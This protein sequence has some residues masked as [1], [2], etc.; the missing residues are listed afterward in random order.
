MKT[1]TLISTIILLLCITIVQAQTITLTFSG[2]NN[3]QPVPLEK[4][5]VENLNKSCDTTLFYPNSTLVLHVLGMDD[6]TGAPDR[7][8]VFQNIPNPVT[9]SAAIKI[10]NPATDDVS[11]VVMDINGKQ[12]CTFSGKLERGYHL[13]DFS[14]G[15][16]GTFIVSVASK[17][18]SQSIKVTSNVMKE[19]GISDL[20]YAGK[21]SNDNMIK[22]TSTGGFQFSSGD[23]LRYTG[24]YNS[25]TKVLEDT[26]QSNQ[27]YTFA[28]GSSSFT[29]GQTLTINHVTSGGVA[30]VN[31]TTTYGTVTN[32]PGEPAKC[33][34]TS[35][36]GSDHQATAVDD[37][38][39]ASAG[40][41]WQFNRKQGY[42]HDGL[43]LTPPWTIF[44]INENADWQTPNDPCNLELGAL[45]RLP[46][47][48]E[49]QNVDISGGW[50][51]WNGPW[52][53]SLKLHAA[54]EISYY[55]GHL[56]GRNFQGNYWSNTQGPPLFQ[57][58]YQAWVLVFNGG[59]CGVFF[60]DMG[61]PHKAYGFSARCLRGN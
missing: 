10:F 1:K 49:W 29:C 20:G 18:Y 58:Y 23:H 8:V 36:L 41:Y 53:S 32:I 45:W 16:S 11:I 13:F 37:S 59:Y 9:A 40:W 55:D 39:E 43:T 38:T 61:Y 27:T 17:G 48:T 47:Y 46:T 35:N 21:I 31:K 12:I 7:L 25:T 4:V 51:N 24:Y 6:P 57:A 26:P 42:K 14:P 56:Y 15:K 28:F 33:W 52:D 34:I 19:N 3:G 44:H 30:L 60:D 5:K 54:G 22:S 2:L 50:K